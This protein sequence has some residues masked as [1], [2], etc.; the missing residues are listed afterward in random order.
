VRQSRGFERLVLFVALVLFLAVPAYA[1]CTDCDGDGVPAPLDCDD[2][3][4]TVYPGAPESCNGRDDD[5]D[6]RRDED[7]VRDGTSECHSGD[8]I[9]VS[10]GWFPTAPPCCDVTV[11]P[12]DLPGD[13]LCPVV[14]DIDQFV[15]LTPGTYSVGS[16]CTVYSSL[17]GLEGPQ[18]TTI[19]SPIAFDQSFQFDGSELHGLT[20]SGPVTGNFSH[21][22]NNVILGDLVQSQYS[23]WDSM[24][25]RNLVKG[26]MRLG[27]G[28]PT[29]SDNIVE[30][31]GIR[32]NSEHTG[33]RA[34]HNVVRRA[35]IGIEVR[36]RD[37][38]YLVEENILEDCDVGIY[39][40]ESF[41]PD[42][43][44]VK[45]NLILRPKVGIDS[46]ENI[47]E[48]LLI[49]NTIIE[50]EQKGIILRVNY[51]GDR[52][53]VEQNLIVGTGW[54]SPIG[55]RGVGIEILM[56]GDVHSILAQN[57]VV[58]HDTGVRF[59]YQ[60]GCFLG[61]LLTFQ[62][63]LIAFNETAGIAGPSGVPYEVLLAAM[64]NDVFGGAADW[65]DFT[66]PTGMDGNISTDP[67][68]VDPDR[69]LFNLRSDSPCIDTGADSPLPLDVAGS[70][71]T[72]DGDGDGIART[73]I[74]AYEFMP[75]DP[76]GLGYW[77]H[78]CSDK[79]Y[80]ELSP[81]DLDQLFST[82]AAMSPAFPECAPL[83]CDRLDT[84][85]P[86]SDMRIKAESHALALWLNLAGQRLRMETPAR[87][88]ALPSATIVA[89]AIAVIEGTLCDSHASRSELELAMNLAEAMTLNGGDFELA[90]SRSH[91][92]VAP[93][94]Q[95]QFTLGL[96]NMGDHPRNY[97]LKSAGPWPTILAIP[98]VTGLQI[99]EVALIPVQVSVPR[100]ATSGEVVTITILATD[101]VSGQ[102]TKRS[103]TVTFDVNEMTGSRTPRMLPSE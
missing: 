7:L 69:G 16:G 46:Y 12:G 85:G 14:Q 32:L 5:C 63:N 102:S 20:I 53:V 59:S 28:T 57:T 34:L 71:R 88:D 29:V 40:N 18:V 76:R 45:S 60:H 2:T 21:I 50:A 43:A 97:Q 74:G 81:D 30:D 99:G 15:C 91:V 24:I 67:L 82:V 80:R 89:D 26:D 86:Q 79:P 64:N 17:I 33:A 1:Q 66:D 37:S 70:P 93:G 42:A 4:A 22:V 23:Y 31:G 41:D 27:R 56:R 10:G 100:L 35:S 103:A 44:T 6:G 54:S 94:E 47:L 51:G 65:L 48:A 52:A 83:V 78:Q 58:G 90:G 49:N 19:N 92:M 11:S 98:Q 68:F 36:R 77:R 61:C 8:E 39:V 73:D 62:S 25:W 3:R 9:C 84:S 96:I 101:T 13:D 95:R 55:P 72:V 75:T 38:A 87:L